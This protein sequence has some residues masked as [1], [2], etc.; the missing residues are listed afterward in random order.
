MSDQTVHATLLFSDFVFAHNTRRDRVL[1]ALE[2]GHKTASICFGSWDVSHARPKCW[3]GLGSVLSNGLLTHA[4]IVEPTTSW[5]L[6]KCYASANSSWSVYLSE[7]I[8]CKWSKPAGFS[9][10]FKRQ[11]NK[12]Q[13]LTFLLWSLGL[14]HWPCSAQLN[15]DP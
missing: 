12:L 2:Q 10:I 8:C 5:L 15:Y 1:V 4:L 14:G 6:S 13:P 11:P 7:V 9:S 3:V